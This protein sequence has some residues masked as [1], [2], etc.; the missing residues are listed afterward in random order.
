[1]GAD[2]LMPSWAH[3]AQRLLPTWRSSGGG[4]RSFA[5]CMWHKLEAAVLP[6]AL[7]IWPAMGHVPMPT[8]HHIAPY[9]CTLLTLLGQFNNRSIQIA[10]IAR[11]TATFDQ[12]LG[13]CVPIHGIASTQKHAASN[14]L[15]R[16]PGFWQRLAPILRLLLT[17]SVTGAV[18]GSAQEARSLGGT[19]SHMGRP[20]GP[21]AGC[22]GLSSSAPVDLLAAVLQQGTAAAC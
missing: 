8:P 13:T 6:P 1:M 10:V 20:V 5:W 18:P 16:H 17:V 12:H 21:A 3:A 7:P 4:P 9:C 14:V 15:C 22:M 2:T 11:N 19:G